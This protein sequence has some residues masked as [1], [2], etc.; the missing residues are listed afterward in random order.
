MDN[1]ISPDHAQ[2]P[3]YSKLCTE[4][5]NLSNNNYTHTAS[6]VARCRRSSENIIVN[7]SGFK[8]TECR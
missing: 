5:Q 2:F 3:N 6:Y 1:I 8:T 4:Q 7:R